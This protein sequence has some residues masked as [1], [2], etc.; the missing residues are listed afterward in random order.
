MSREQYRILTEYLHKRGNPCLLAVQIS[1]YTGLRLGEALGLAWEDIDLEKQCM[2]ICRSLS[3]R[4][5]RKA[6]SLG[7]TKTKKTRTVDFGDT[8]AEILRRATIPQARESLRYGPMCKVNYV[9]KTV[10]R[11]WTYNDLWALSRNEAPPAGY[12]PISFA[13]LI[14]VACWLDKLASGEQ[15][16]V[17]YG[18]LVRD[19]MRGKREKTWLCPRVNPV[20]SRGVGINSKK[21]APW[22]GFL[23]EYLFDIHSMK[24]ETNSDTKCTPLWLFVK[25]CTFR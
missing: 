17:P 23:S 14:Q 6:A 16:N 25:R 7:P 21:T 5:S 18:N 24:V 12:I 8:L 19:K 11:N 10:D 22:R 15:E 13:A 3:Y 9:Q 2:T 1:Y 4:S 20:F